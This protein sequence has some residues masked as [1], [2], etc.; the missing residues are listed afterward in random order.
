MYTGDSDAR[1]IQE[2]SRPAEAVS[3]L[4]ST[5]DLCGEGIL[6]L[7]HSLPRISDFERS[8]GVKLGVGVSSVDVRGDTTYR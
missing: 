2:K 8:K 6:T 5:G 1:S 7:S 3:G 4:V